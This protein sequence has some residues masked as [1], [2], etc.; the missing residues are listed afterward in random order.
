MLAAVLMPRSPRGGV[1][2]APLHAAPRLIIRADDMG[3][4]H[5]GN[6]A[7]L[8]CCTEG[9]ATTV[10]VIAPAPWFPEAVSM[11]KQHPEIDVGVHLA[12]SSEWDNVKWRPLTASLGL[13]EADGWFPPM[14][15][16]N[17][18]YPGRSLKEMHWTLAEVEREFRAQIELVRSHLP[19]ISHLSGHMGCNHVSPEVST[20]TKQLADEYGVQVDP[21]RSVLQPAGFDGPHRTPDE[22][23]SSFVA[24]LKSLQSGGTYLFVEHPGF[25]T[26]ELRAIHHI[27]YEDVADDRQGVTD[28]LTD[29]EILAAIESRGIQRISYRDLR[30]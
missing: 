13:Q 10:E 6:E 18:N 25:D 7:I 14:I 2:S 15:F 4:A 9:I 1:Q 20:L 23:R 27:G 22:K 5:S 17:R 29:P 16:P 30:R 8:K 24:M 28:L 11:L 21:D 3:F 12:L 19:H 26:P